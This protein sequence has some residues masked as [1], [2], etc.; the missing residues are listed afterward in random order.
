MAL[1]TE[2]AERFINCD[3]VYFNLKRNL[4]KYYANS[5]VDKLFLGRFR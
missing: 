2:F 1:D 3:I 4:K 5:E